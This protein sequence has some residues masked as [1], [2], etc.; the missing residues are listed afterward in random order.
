MN[1]AAAVRRRP[2]KIAIDVALLVGFVLEFATRERSFDPRYL[3]HGW[4]GIVLLAVLAAHLGGNW[5]WVKR[6]ARRR[7]QDR[8]ARLGL[9]NLSFGVTAAT[10]ILSGVPLWVGWTGA[11]AVV[12]VHATS[13]FLSIVLMAVHIG[14]NQRRIRALLRRRQSIRSTAAPETWP[15]ASRASA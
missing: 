1:L 12:V 4:T 6:V 8:E 15:A 11:Q 2:V 5:G 7:G 3:V 9:L 13:G 14:W 10:C